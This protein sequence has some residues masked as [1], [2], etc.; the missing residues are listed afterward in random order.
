MKD[1]NN[2]NLIED[3][4]EQQGNGQGEELYHDE[5]AEVDSGK[6]VVAQTAKQN[7]VSIIILVVIIGIIIYF[8]F[9]RHSGKEEKKQEYTAPTNVTKPISASEELS[10]PSIPNSPPPPPQVSLPKAPTI[11]SESLPAPQLPKLPQAAPK[12]TSSGILSGYLPTQNSYAAKQKIQTKVGAPM[13]LTDSNSASSSN[14]KKDKQLYVENFIPAHTSSAQQRVTRVGNMA[15]LIA[16]GKIID[17]VLETPINTNYPGPV[18]AV[19]SSD[20]YSENGKNILVPRG[21]RLVGQF[22]G[23]YTPGQ[24]RIILTWDRI[25]MPNGYD[26]AVS[27][28][29]IGANGTAGVEGIVDTQ[30][31]PALTNAVLYSALNVSFAKIVSEVTK[32]NTQSQTTS[33][34]GVPGTGSGVTTT[35]TTTPTQQAINQQTQNLGNTTQDL[36]KQFTTAKPFITLD[37]GTLV[38]VFVN[39]DILFPKNLSDN[40]RVVE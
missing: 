17:S 14:D 22:S 40:V 26:I 29:A 20:V 39:R 24:T 36:A 37:Q 11:P 31:A 2:S 3:N 27:S 13:M 25:I 8:S 35:A 34:S 10:L 18:R 16:Q 38:S 5:K 32:S 1:N 30:I 33:T 28:P 21:S 4:T 9:F 6:T 15:L 19:V 7:M 12:E 23:G